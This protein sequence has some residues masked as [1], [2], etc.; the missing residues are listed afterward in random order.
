MSEIKFCKYQGTGND[1]VV[2]DNRTKL[3]NITDNEQIKLLCDRRFGVGADGLM[4]LQIADGYD[5]EMVYFN[6]DGNPGSMCGNGGRCIVA[7]AKEL[8]IIENE[9]NFL[10]VD[11]PHY[12]RISEL[13]IELQMTDVHNVGKRNEDYV[14]HTGSP[15]YV[16]QVQDL[17]SLDVFSA[18]RSIRYHD[19][20]KISGI[21]VNFYTLHENHLSVRT[22][23][24]GVE[25]E[26][27]ACGTG[28]TAVAIAVAC[29]ND[30]NGAIEK[31]INVL[32]GELTVRFNKLGDSCT[33]IFLCGPAERV[34]TGYY[35][36]AK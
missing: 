7:F 31:K 20:Y 24:R 28:V 30:E 22:Y 10:A 1:F 8:G 36:A 17:P 33:D 3:F 4:C 12:A 15:H 2:I 13:G 21:N 25:A 29:A 19:E 35:S 34:F 26:T 6:A 18:G 27:Y 9:T 23:E 14:I 16:Q 32:G 11:G 5:F